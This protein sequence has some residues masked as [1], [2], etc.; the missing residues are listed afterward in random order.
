MKYIQTNGIRLHYLETEGAKPA[1][2]LLHGLTANAHCFDGLLKAGLSPAFHTLSVDLRGRGLSDKPSSGY[3]M[4]H[5]ADD[6]LG[7]LDQLGIAKATFVGHSFGAFVSLYLATHWPERVE[8]MI[9]L[10][11]AAQMHPETRQML[12]P[13]MA[14]LDQKMPSF[15]SYISKVKEAPY[16]TYWE[17]TMLSYYRADV[18]DNE[19]GT[20]QTRSNLANIIEAV[21]GVLG[22]PWLDYLK[23]APQPTLLLNATE[24]YTM[25]F[26]LLPKELAMETVEMMPNCRYQ[27]VWG[28][29]QT[30][31][32][33]QG[34]V[35]IV[36]AV[37]NFLK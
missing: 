20:A 19:D 26:P 4:R 7:L 17:D 21:T 5:H 12:A 34:A 32:Y 3:T 27:G 28:N 29:H 14:R 10:D 31:L 6:I 15:E 18:K 33:G 37:R 11:A 30:M 2:I 13:A 9:M 16:L 25:G 23:N 24:A 8:K 22:E 36:A 35:E 1:L